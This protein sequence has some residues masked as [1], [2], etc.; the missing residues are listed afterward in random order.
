MTAPAPHRF[1]ILSTQRSG[2]NWLED[3]LGDHPEIT[4][5]PNEVF[6]KTLDRPIAY[7]RY[8]RS[9]PARRLLGAALPPVS[10]ARYLSWL[11]DRTPPESTAFGFR[12]MYDQLR[13]NPSLGPLLGRGTRIVHLVRSN[14]LETHVSVVAAKQSGLW[15]TRSTEKKSPSVELDTAGLVEELERRVAL[16]ERHRRLVSRLPSLEVA[17][18]EY[19]AEPAATDVRVLDFLGVEIASLGSALQRSGS[20]VLRDRISNVDEVAAALAGSRF[21]ALLD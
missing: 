16:I 12:L 18:E 4:M 10:K 21:V 5:F 19:V 7:R 8:R 20:R 6:R 2:S 11:A 9:T 1:V 15:V 14:V 3:R 13:R 17:Y